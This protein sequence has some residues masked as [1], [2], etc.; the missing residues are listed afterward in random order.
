MKQ[1]IPS[2]Y[3]HKL[4]ISFLLLGVVPL[5]IVGP[6]TYALTK[7]ILYRRVHYKSDTV[8]QAIESSL[9]R[10]LG[11]SLLMVE[12]I[13]ND[14]AFS[15][16][17]RTSDS[18]K[19]AHAPLYDSLYLLLSG[20]EIKP[21]IHIIDK[22]FAVVLNTH[23]TPKEYYM[24]QYQ[25]WGVMRKALFAQGEPVL[26]YHSNL[27][28][29]RRALT[30]AQAKFFVDGSLE[31]IIFVD[32]YDE[33]IASLLPFLGDHGEQSILLLD[34]HL[35][36]SLTFQGEVDTTSLEQILTH[37]EKSD[38]YM[39]KG[40]GHPSFIFSLAHNEGF[41]FT[42]LSYYPLA[43][44]DELLK[45]VA[46]IFVILASVMTVMSIILALFVSRNAAKPLS[47]VV[48]VLEKVGS[49]DFSTLTDIDRNDEFGRL[50]LSVNQMVGKMKQLIE[51]NRQKEQSLRT[52]EI[53]SLMSQTNPHF[54][55]NCLET[56]KWYIL[57]EDTKEASQT[58]V[59]LGSLLRSSLDLG[60]GIITVQEEIEFIGKYI[61]L[62]KRR[63]GDRVH[64]KFEIDP[65]VLS[66]RIPRLLFQ[67]VVENAI[68]HGLEK[69]IG[70]GN[71]LIRCYKEQGYLHFVT[72]DDG[73]G[74]REK[75]ARHLS[76]YQE[77]VD[78][79][80][81]GSGLQNLIRRL[82]LYY[83]DSAGIEVTSS[84][85]AGTQISIYINLM[86]G[87]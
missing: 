55:F 76:K 83:G 43:Q 18:T 64:A 14:E 59:E 45:L 58:V 9:A 15:P 19:T 61:S 56:I 1:W 6:I 31:G 34:E 79:T 73:L 21:A 8:S 50:G 74:M 38:S 68:M 5:L 37:R 53:K 86:I 12:S 47:Q 30:L 52:S 84:E 24:E 46:V 49:G 63:M 77:T 3:F 27:P 36:T 72:K 22:D 82:H 26:Y 23:P 41:G 11:E 16:A 87:L 65:D 85:G 48:D 35:N 66:V 28:D 7:T 39:R 80:E 69:K 40:D 75:L 60:E 78:V 13:I 2:R 10:Q 67:P 70:R 57:L 29:D 71:L 4:L 33:H 32:L 62:Q 44:V 17:F 25:S 42:I 54:I 81:G 20:C 51:T